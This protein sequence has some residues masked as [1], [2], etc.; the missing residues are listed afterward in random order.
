MF[1][2]D[3]GDA[4]LLAAAG[5]G[6]AELVVLTVDQEQAALR[7]VTL[8]RSSWPELAVIAGAWPATPFR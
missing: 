4:E 2:G 6:R 1:Y 5:A 3:I 7:A 8:L